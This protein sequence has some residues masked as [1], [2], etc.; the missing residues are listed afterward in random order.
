MTVFGPGQC[1][2]VAQAI[3]RA[4]SL[5]NHPIVLDGR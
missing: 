3:V 5:A 1:D 4:E 2:A